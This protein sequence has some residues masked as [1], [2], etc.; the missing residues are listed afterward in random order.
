MLRFTLPITIQ[1]TVF[2]RLKA[3]YPWRKEATGFQH[4]YS[5]REKKKIGYCSALCAYLRMLAATFWI[6]LFGGRYDVYIVDQVTVVLPLLWFFRKKTLFYCH[7]PDKLLCVE[8][9]SALKKIYRLVLDTAEELSMLFANLVLVNSEFTKE[10]VRQ[11]FPI[12]TRLSKTPSVLYPVVDFQR[13]EEA[14]S[15]Q[16]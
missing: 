5:V 8:R 3:R 9:R 15:L 16:R 10:V 14:P 6:I 4:L 2:R 12:F 1:I 13:F 11:A 7:Y